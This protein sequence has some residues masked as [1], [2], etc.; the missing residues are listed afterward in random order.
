MISAKIVGG[1]ARVSQV[2]DRKRV[3][4]QR[5]LARGVNEASLLLLRR[6]QQKLSG[7]V[8]NQRSGKLVGSAHAVLAKAGEQIVGGV[9]AAGGA[10]WYGRVH[11]YGGKKSYPIVP[12][13]KRALAFFGA[14]ASLGGAEKRAFYFKQGARRGTLRPKL[15]GAAH[16]AGLVVVKSVEHP[17]LPRRSFMKSSLEELRGELVAKILR[18]AAEA[19]R[20]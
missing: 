4:L 6:V 10:A 15:Y 7:E 19:L 11:E 14:E 8:L 16:E 9:D 17:P 2:L 3:E 5:A 12:V 18:A 20:R 13:S 1:P